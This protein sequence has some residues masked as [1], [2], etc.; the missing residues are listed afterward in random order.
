M[1]PKKVRQG[2]ESSCSA[3]WR[4]HLMWG[5]R[6]IWGSPMPAVPPF[7]EALLQGTQRGQKPPKEAQF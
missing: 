6:S 5:P 4:V 1:L 2:P 3:S 7:R